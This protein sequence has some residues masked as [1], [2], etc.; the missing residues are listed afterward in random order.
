MLNQGPED[1]E[2]LGKKLN[3]SPQELGCIKDSPPGCGLLYCGNTII[4][5]EDRFPKDTELYK[6]MTTRLEEVVQNE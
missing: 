5:F 3:I 2:L 4:P 1:R 6:L